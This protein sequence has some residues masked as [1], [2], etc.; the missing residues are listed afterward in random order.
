MERPDSVSFRTS[1]WNFRTFEKTNC[2][3]KT[4]AKA[5]ALHE[6]L[7]WLESLS[8]V[9]FLQAFCGFRIPT[10]KELRSMQMHRPVVLPEPPRC[11]RFRVLRPRLSWRPLL[12]DQSLFLAWLGM[13]SNYNTCNINIKRKTQEN[14]NSFTSIIFPRVL[15]RLCTWKVV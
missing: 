5:D 15:S 11:Y 12:R 14:Q 13:Q 8:G 3:A 6:L 1:W 10:P 9:L 4:L 2:S 7:H